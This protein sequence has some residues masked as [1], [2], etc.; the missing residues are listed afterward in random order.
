[1]QEYKGYQIVNDGTFGHKQIKP[2][3]KGSVHLTLR[4][5]Y[6]TFGFAQRAI[7]LYLSQKVDT[8]GKVE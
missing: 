1:M 4:G 5:T 8:N 3:G 6:T 2:I 7:D